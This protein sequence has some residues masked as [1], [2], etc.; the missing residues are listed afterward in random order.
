MAK[1]LFQD[2]ESYKYDS[3]MYWNPEIF[4]EN[5][6]GD[7]TQR[8]TDKTKYKLKKQGNKTYVHEYQK[9][10]SGFYENMELAQF[11]CDTQVR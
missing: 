10:K 6:H 9:H 7:V 3:E 2:L 8:I 5:K 11:P 1:V 4:L